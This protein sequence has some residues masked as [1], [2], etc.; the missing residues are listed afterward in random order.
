MAL[1]EQPCYT[2]INFRSDTDTPN[3][4]QLKSD[5]GKFNSISI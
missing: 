5:L 1:I 4:M 3:E 2:I